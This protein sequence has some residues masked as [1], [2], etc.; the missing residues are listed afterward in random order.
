VS[1][2]GIAATVAIAIDVDI[3]DPIETGRTLEP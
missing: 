1:S 2:V 3:R